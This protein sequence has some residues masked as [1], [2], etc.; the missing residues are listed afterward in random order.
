MTKTCKNCQEKK[1]LD[2]FTTD[3]RTRDGLR[4]VCED[5]RTAVRPSGASVL[6][7]VEPETRERQN[8]SQTATETRRKALADYENTFADIVKGLD[9]LDT[10][11]A[12]WPFDDYSMTEEQL[13]A[14]DGIL[15]ALLRGDLYGS[16]YL[17]G[18]V[19]KTAEDAAR[20][21]SHLTEILIEF[22][23]EDKEKLIRV[24]QN[25]INSRVTREAA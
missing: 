22:G 4:K 12:P 23:V 9:T 25:V 10:L 7:P 5:C 3:G 2:R 8:G 17:M 14:A 13:G 16:H 19:C 20:L 21:L 11:N 1:P 6:A 24:T 18:Q 15:I